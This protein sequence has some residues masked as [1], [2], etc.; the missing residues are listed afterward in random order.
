MKLFKSYY[1]I[2]TKM[3]RNNYVFSVEG[4]IGSGKSTLIPELKNMLNYIEKDGFQYNIVYLTEPVDIW[5][6]IKDTTGKNIIEKFYENNE[7]YAFSFQMMAYI[8]RI[9]QIKEKLSKS[10]NTIII[11]E[12]SIFTDKNVFAK[13][14]YD[15]NH[16][17]EIN[18]QIYLKWFDE[19]HKDIPYKGVIYIKTPP[20]VCLERIKKRNR[21]GE[22][23]P[24]KYLENC[25]KYHDNWLHKNNKFPAVL[26]NGEINI[27]NK[28]K[29]HDYLFY[30]IIPFISDHIKKMEKK[31]TSVSEFYGC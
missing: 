23:I 29:Y 14:L 15:S 18:Y 4:N 7:K 28:K 1:F 16:I 22:N 13:M 9:H 17:E 21:E 2:I 20:A 10:Y 30:R 19:F 26:F 24:I 11:C 31:M 6:S 12:R 25:D 5:Q 8:S 3:T 27:E